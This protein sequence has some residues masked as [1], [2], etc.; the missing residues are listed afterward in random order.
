MPAQEKPWIHL[1]RVAGGHCHHRCLDRAT[2]ASRSTGERGGSAYAMQKNLKQLSLAL[3]NY[4][5]THSLFPPAAIQNSTT[6]NATNN[7]GTRGRNTTWK[8]TW[9]ILMLPYLDQAPLHTKYNFGNATIFTPANNQILQT[10]LASLR[11]PS[12]GGH[13]PQFIPNGFAAPIGF[14]KGNY[15][16]PFGAEDA[17]SEGDFS[18]KDHRSLMNPMWQ[19]GAKIAQ[20]TD[21]TSNTIAVTELLTSGTVTDGRGAWGIR[22]VAASP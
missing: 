17:F 5:A 19:W 21:G 1:D 20:V 18:R 13:V 14:S 4:S 11:S 9:V 6:W 10:N 16:A 7:G 22:P 15:A 8:A 2:A 12:D 3:H